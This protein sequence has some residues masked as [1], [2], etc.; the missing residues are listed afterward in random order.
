ML[1]LRGEQGVPMDFK[2]V[3][4]YRHT[5]AFSPDLDEEVFLCPLEEAQGET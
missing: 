5:R 3:C 1:I 2:Q 4:V